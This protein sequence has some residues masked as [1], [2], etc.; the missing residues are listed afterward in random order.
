MVK[1]EDTESGDWTAK[2]LPLFEC[3]NELLVTHADWKTKFQE[4][5]NH[6]KTLTGNCHPWCTNNRLKDANGKD[7]AHQGDSAREVKSVGDATS[8]VFGEKN[9]SLVSDIHE[10]LEGNLEL[11]RELAFENNCLSLGG[12]QATIAAAKAASEGPPDPTDHRVATNPHKSRH[13]E[14]WCKEVLKTAGVWSV[15]SARELAKHVA[16]AGTTLP[17]RNV[18]TNGS[19]VMMHWLL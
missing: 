15:V 2:R 17:A 19:S 9:I 3:T 5:V 6:P 11:Q 18:R 7:I 8:H 1:C 12:L 10:R 16:E 14:D 13:K 4:V